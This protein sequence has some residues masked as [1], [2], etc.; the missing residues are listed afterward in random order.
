MH[1]T[2]QLLTGS[3][4]RAS[5]YLG[6]RMLLLLGEPRRGF[7]F[8]S[9]GSQAGTASRLGRLQPPGTHTGTTPQLF[10]TTP[11]PASNR[12]RSNRPMVKSFRFISSPS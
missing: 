6:L 10:L 5:V 7:A 1:G 12:N 9:Q 4:P 8:C 2:C 11:S 3:V